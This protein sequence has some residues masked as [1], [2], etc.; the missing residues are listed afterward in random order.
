[1]AG[2][3]YEFNE[4]IKHY[5]VTLPKMMAIGGMGRSGTTMLWSVCNS[6]PDIMVSKE[7]RV[8]SYLGRDYFQHI[9]GLRKNWW[10]NAIIRVHKTRFWHSSTIGSALFVYGYLFKLLVS[11]G[12]RKPVRAEAVRQVL[13]SLFP[14]ASVVG[15]KRP[16]YLWQ[17]RNLTR[18]EHM[19]P[20]II[21]RDCRDVVRSSLR[22]YQTTW[23]D[24]KN[25]SS[26]ERIA[27][28]W[29]EAIDI[30]EQYAGKI[31]IIRYEDFVTDPLCAVKTMAEWLG[32]DPAGFQIDS[33]HAESVGRWEQELSEKQIDDVL[34][35]AGPVLERL[36]YL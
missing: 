32:V 9:V 19:I 28:Q 2:N 24:N 7:F 21:Y 8:F 29:V 13:H 6:H 22:M 25:K 23:R 11:V 20:I 36:E 4:S 17:L 31:H 16:Y 35:V 12:S 1:V 27:A 26:P 3:K 30:M 14:T 34:M 15:D 5:A 18:I 33:V 10:S